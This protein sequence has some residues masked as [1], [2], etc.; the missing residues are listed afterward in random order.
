MP[1]ELILRDFKLLMEEIE[2]IRQQNDLNTKVIQNL[3]NENYR[4]YEENTKLQVQN[5]QLIQAQNQNHQVIQHLETNM[6]RAE[7]E[8]AELQVRTSV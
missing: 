7:S 4:L 5:D 6:D 8:V 3:Q 1:T 2:Q